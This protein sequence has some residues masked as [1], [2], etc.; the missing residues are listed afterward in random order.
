MRAGALFWPSQ[1]TGPVQRRTDAAE[2]DAGVKDGVTR[3]MHDGLIAKRSYE[4]E[5]LSGK[6]ADGAR[7]RKSERH[8]G[9]S[10][11]LPHLEF[12]RILHRE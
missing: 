9:S 12:V 8:A 4:A 7:G 1:P 11:V 5:D 10:I 6:N 2:R 3:E